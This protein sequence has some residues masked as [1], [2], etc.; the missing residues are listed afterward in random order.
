MI[1]VGF[2]AT[3][4]GLLPAVQ[5]F[6]ALIAVLCLVLLIALAEMSRRPRL[7]HLEIS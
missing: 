1:G 6:A 3:S 5:A 2:L 4:I 7:N